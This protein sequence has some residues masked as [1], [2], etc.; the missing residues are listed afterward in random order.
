ME[1]LSQYL[2]HPLYWVQPRTL[3][4]EF[5]LRNDVG[6]LATLKF[7]TPFGSL[8]TARASS[9]TWS[10]KRIGF[11]RPV[12]TVREIDKEDNIAVY[13]PRW[14]GAEGDVD[15]NDQTYAFR[16]SNFWATQFDIR[17]SDGHLLIT[18]RSGSKKHALGDLFKTQAEVSVAD[19]GANPEVLALLILIGWYIIVLH[20]EDSAAIAATSATAAP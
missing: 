8:A 1:P 10:L 3:T 11:F 15:L 4:R 5:E 19:P 16:T 13:R 6:V 14:T 2:A 12:I 9:G 17:D 20:N 7:E 18:Y